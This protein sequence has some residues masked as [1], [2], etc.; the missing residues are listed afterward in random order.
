MSPAFICINNVQ[1]EESL[2]PMLTKF[3]DSHPFL[4]KGEA[5]FIVDFLRKLP[6]NPT[7]LEIGTFRGMTAILMA[8]QR[9]DAR[10]YT[11]DSHIGLLNYHQLT[12]S[13]ELVNLNIIK[14]GVV[15]RVIHIPKSSQLYDPSDIAPIDLLFIDGDHSFSGVSH[16]YSKFEPFVRQGGY[17]IFHDHLSHKGVT[18]FCHRLISCRKVWTLYSLFIIRKP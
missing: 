3:L 15:D 7:I 5:Y 13:V 11:I 16:D 18:E 6:K 9:K 17:I 12:S 4:K 14:Y 8:Q 2:M 10:V 1:E